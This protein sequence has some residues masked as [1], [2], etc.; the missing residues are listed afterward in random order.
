MKN[1]LFFTILAVIVCGCSA[2]KRIYNSKVYEDIYVCQGEQDFIRKSLDLYREQLNYLEN[3]EYSSQND[4]VYILEMCGVQ[5]NVDIT[6]WNKHKTLSYT[7][8]QGYFETK[9]KSLFT[10]H[11]IKLVS[12]WDIPG[13]KKEEDINSNMLPSEL[14]YATKIVFNKGKYHIDCIYFKEF[15]CLERDGMD[16]RD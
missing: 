1:Y 3:F 4:T 2:Q 5:G 12:E 13:I 14:L 15:F 6:I 10:K 8:E 16:F 11:I 9:N 7:N